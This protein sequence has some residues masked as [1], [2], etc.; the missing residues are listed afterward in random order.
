MSDADTELVRKTARL[1]LLEIDE[2]EARALGADFARIL[3]HFRALAQLDVDGVEPTSGAADLADVLRA[4][5]PR[6]SPPAERL[7]ANAPLRE[8]GFFAVPKTIRE[9]G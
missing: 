7:L 4:D 9:E 5:E 8:D 6:P 2:A 1:A 3:E